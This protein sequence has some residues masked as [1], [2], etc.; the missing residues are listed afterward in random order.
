MYIRVAKTHYKLNVFS[1]QL[2]NWFNITENWMALYS[3]QLYG[4]KT[5]IILKDVSNLYITSCIN[6]GFVST[7]NNLGFC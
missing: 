4:S 2:K 7:V 3:L 5:Q 1:Q 6:V